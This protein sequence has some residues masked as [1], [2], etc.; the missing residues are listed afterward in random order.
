MSSGTSYDVDALEAL[1]KYPPVARV[2]R[3]SRLEE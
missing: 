3:G 1:A 2:Q